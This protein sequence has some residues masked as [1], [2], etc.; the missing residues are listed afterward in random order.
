MAKIPTE[1][2]PSRREMQLTKEGKSHGYFLLMIKQREYKQ[3]KNPS[4]KETLRLSSIEGYSQ[5]LHNTL[6]NQMKTYK[7]TKLKMQPIF[8]FPDYFLC[9]LLQ[10]LAWYIL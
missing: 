3:I 2:V 9:T 6:E 4:N 8:F 7:L 5:I 1:M 10:G